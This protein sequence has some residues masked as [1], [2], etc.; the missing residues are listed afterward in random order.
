MPKITDLAVDSAITGAEIVPV[1]DGSTTKRTTVTA[2]ATF[3]LDQLGSAAAADTTDFATAAQGAL[4]ATATQPDDNV[5]TLSSGTASDGQ[6]P[7]ADGS[8]NIA[9]ENAAAAG[10][11]TRSATGSIGAGT[12]N[13]TL[14]DG[15]IY[16]ITAT[17]A[18]AITLDSGVTGSNVYES[19]IWVDAQGYAVTFTNG[20]VTSSVDISGTAG[21][22][23]KLFVRHYYDSDAGAPA[24]EVYQYNIKS[25]GVT[26]PLTNLVAYWPLVSDVADAAGSYDLT[27]DGSAALIGSAPYGLDLTD[28]DGDAAV[29]TADS[30]IDINGVVDAVRGVQ[31]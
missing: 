21:D 7:T 11:I 24:F 27:L 15:V 28:A 25:A 23:T 10:G 14:A 13:P 4:A 12:W 9:W 26:L 1:V 17:E 6:V 30:V 29:R 3:A 16:E 8:G 18:L 2:L 20:D 19:E 22:I 5:T 31:G